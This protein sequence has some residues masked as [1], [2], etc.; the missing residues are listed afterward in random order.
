MRRSFSR[1]PSLPCF[2]RASNSSRGSLF[3]FALTTVLL[4][5][6]APAVGAS[7]AA[8]CRTSALVDRMPNVVPPMAGKEPIW[9]LGAAQNSWSED[10]AIDA[11]FVLS[12]RQDGDL[13]VIGRR[14]KSPS[15]LSFVGEDGVSNVLQVVEPHRSSLTP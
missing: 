13:T 14:R 3:A 10:Q 2:D 9:L 1:L 12:R 7:T 15:E 11:A 6:V 5:A 8:D 4:G